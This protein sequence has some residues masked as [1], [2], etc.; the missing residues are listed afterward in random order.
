MTKIKWIVPLLISL[1]LTGCGP[2]TIFLRPGLDTPSQHVA[3][4]NQLLDVGKVDDA[5]REFER[6]KEL[7]PNY[8]R[9]YVGIGVALG[10]KGD[11]DA[12][13]EALAMAEKMADSAPEQDA[14]K[15]GYAQLDALRNTTQGR[16]KEN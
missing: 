11:I 16:E 12:G 7:D 8:V 10:R 5:F 13:M 14:V 15:K 1:F 2:D 4:G 6:A 3:N 9:A